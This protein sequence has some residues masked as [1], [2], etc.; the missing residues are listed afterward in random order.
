MLIGIC[1]LYLY[2]PKCYSL[3]NKRSILKGFIYRLRKK[4]NISISEIGQKDIWK[5]TIIGISYISEHRE[6]IDKSFE[7]IIKDIENNPEIEL[8]DYDIS[9]I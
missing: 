7:N 9:T 2:I 6:I 3:K 5:N 8:V 1:K 4:Y